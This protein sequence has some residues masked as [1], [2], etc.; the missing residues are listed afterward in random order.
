MAIK[1][2]SGTRTGAVTSATLLCPG[3]REQLSVD[4]SL[5]TN[6]QAAQYLGGS[7]DTGQRDVGVSGHH[8]RIAGLRLT[9]DASELDAQRAREHDE[10][11]LAGQAVRRCRERRV[12]LH[13]PHAGLA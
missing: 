13:A 8:D 4:E 12:E 2:A 9:D 5:P 7:A 3:R 6:G 11:L 1:R 10:D